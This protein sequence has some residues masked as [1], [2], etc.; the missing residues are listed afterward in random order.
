M[1]TI[2]LIAMTD[3]VEGREDEYH[4][5][6]NGRHLD[7]VLGTAGFKAVQRF[8]FKPTKMGREA[9][10]RFLAIYDIEADSVEDAQQALLDRAA[11]ESLMPISDAM[12][13]K[14]VTWWFEAINERKETS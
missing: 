7:D 5:W 11:D 3:P 8:E 13:P 2:R 10:R 14:P 12:A 4:D 9:P 6:Y 1:A